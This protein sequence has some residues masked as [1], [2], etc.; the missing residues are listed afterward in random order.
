MSILFNTF[1]NRLFATIVAG[2][3]LSNVALAGHG[4][5]GG[6]GG[7]SFGG[8]QGMAMQRMTQPVKNFSA[9]KMTSQP[10][11]M[12]NTQSNFVSKSFGNLQ[13]LKSTPTLGKFDTKKLGSTSLGTVKTSD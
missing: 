13:T 12:K 5:S 11:L 7:K 8:G 2:L 10:Q 1:R 4:H 6:G 3:A 9:P